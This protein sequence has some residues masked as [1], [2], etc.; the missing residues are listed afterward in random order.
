MVGIGTDGLTTRAYLNEVLHS[1]GMD[2]QPLTYLI[3]RKAKR[4]KRTVRDSAWEALTVFLLDCGASLTYPTDRY[5][6]LKSC[7]SIKSQKVNSTC[8]KKKTSQQKKSD[9]Y[10]VLKSCIL[11]KSPKVT[12]ACTKKKR[13]QQKKSVSCILGYSDTLLVLEWWVLT[14][15][16]LLLEHIKMRCCIRKVKIFNLLSTWIVGR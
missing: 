7:I 12:L 4:D 9:R 13:S 5:N 14:L 10:D 3:S 16:D 11:I 8:T 2:I 6:V 15:T 1:K